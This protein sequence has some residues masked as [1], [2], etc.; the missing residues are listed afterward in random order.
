MTS[1][2]AVPRKNLLCLCNVV[3]LHL[4]LRGLTAK[5]AKSTMSDSEE[6]KPL[7]A[8]NIAVKP[9]AAAPKTSNAAVS[10]K[11]GVVTASNPPDA[12]RRKAAQKAPVIDTSDSEDDKV[13]GTRAKPAAKPGDDNSTTTVRLCK[14]DSV[15]C[16][17]RPE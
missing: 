5:T 10:S 1:C 4:F 13:L 15:C 7:A 9:P 2:S 6:D 17:T 16:S 12:I 3:D 8:R 11:P 14:E